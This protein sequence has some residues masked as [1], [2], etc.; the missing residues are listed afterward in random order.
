MSLNLDASTPLNTRV[1]RFGS[2]KNTS[3]RRGD[4]SCWSS[5][6]E[7]WPHLS[8]GTV[9]AY[10][11]ENGVEDYFISGGKNIHNRDNR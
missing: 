1:K 2:N 5:I 6:R 9:F 8:L 3:L 11:L 4:T 7:D 10:H